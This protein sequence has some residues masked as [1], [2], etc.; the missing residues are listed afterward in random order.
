MPSDGGRRRRG[1]FACS[2]FT[3]SSHLSSRSR[4]F[5][6]IWVPRLVCCRP[7]RIW[8]GCYQLVAPATGPR[9]VEIQEDPS[10]TDL[11]AGHRLERPG[12]HILRVR[13][14]AA[15]ISDVS[16]SKAWTT[17]SLA[18]RKRDAS[19]QDWLSWFSFYSDGSC[20]RTPHQ[21]TTT[22]LM[23]MH[24]TPLKTT[25]FCVWQPHNIDTWYV[26]RHLHGLSYQMLIIGS[27]F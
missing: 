4:G 2:F 14:S 18:A 3:S 21:S 12:F 13:P 9:Q 17:I 5:I 19:C 15:D 10:S 27:R 24:P 25:C 16:S 6:S 23:R 8:P 22:P 1:I 20:P 11:H 7:H 26:H